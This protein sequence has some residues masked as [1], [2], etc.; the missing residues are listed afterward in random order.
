MLVSCDSRGNAS[1]L[2]RSLGVQ[3][4]CVQDDR[5]G[6][7]VAKANLVSQLGPQRV[8]AIGN[9]VA[10]GL[11]L[12]RAVLSIAVCGVEGAAVQ[13]IRAA[14]VFTLSSIDALELFIHSDRLKATLR[15]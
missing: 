14:H 1:K 11:M 3:L 6:E 9:G 10:D 15:R 8:A 5:R 13:S 2:S 4:R 12:R 7:A